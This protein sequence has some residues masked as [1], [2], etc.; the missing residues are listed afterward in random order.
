MRTGNGALSPLAFQP[1]PTVPR[2]VDGEAHFNDSVHTCRLEKMFETNVPLPSKP[3]TCKVSVVHGMEAEPLICF[4]FA[5]SGIVLI[6]ELSK[7]MKIASLKLH[8]SGILA[9]EAVAGLR[10]KRPGGQRER[11][12][13]V[14]YND[15]RM[16]LYC[17]WKPI[18]NV[19]LRIKPPQ[20]ETYLNVLQTREVPP[21][22]GGPEGSAAPDV[23]STTPAIVGIKDSNGNRLTLRLQ[24]GIDVRVGLLLRP[25]GTAATEL[26]R[27]VQEDSYRK[28]HDV[29]KAS[30]RKAYQL[31]PS[32]TLACELTSLMSLLGP[33][34]APSV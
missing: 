15:Y 7:T 2:G 25:L 28:D 13:L 29:S 6:V 20:T 32:G 31:D 26:L 27:A 11:D 33:L 4:F 12:L 14:L 3:S 8:L 22:Y 19:S 18:W 17:G 23:P 34:T 9:V 5:D 21:V 10:S 16:E 30:D 24:S 1:T